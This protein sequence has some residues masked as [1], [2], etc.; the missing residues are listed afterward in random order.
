MRSYWEERTRE[1]SN[2]QVAGSSPMRF[3]RFSSGS[4]KGLRQLSEMSPVD[5]HVLKDCNSEGLLERSPAYPSRVETSSRGFD[6]RGFTQGFD[7]R[8]HARRADQKQL[9]EKLSSLILSL[10]PAEA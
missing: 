6:K 1:R 3:R 5:S 9:Q 4:P 7:K 8:R 2:D 10:C